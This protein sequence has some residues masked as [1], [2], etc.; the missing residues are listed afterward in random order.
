MKTAEAQAKQFVEDVRNGKK[1]INE[2]RRIIGLD[3]I[4][5]CDEIL[6]MFVRQPDDPMTTEEWWEMYG[7]ETEDD[8]AK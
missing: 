6:T 8:N 4:P 5:G 3:P 7:E 2:V 1:S